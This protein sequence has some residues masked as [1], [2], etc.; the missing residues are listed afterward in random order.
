VDYSMVRFVG[1]L[2]LNLWDCG[3][4]AAF[5]Q[6]YF[7]SQKDHIFKNVEV[8]IH[9]FDIVSEEIEQDIESFQQCVE[10]IQKFSASA[11]VF[12]LIHKMD[13]VP[14]EQRDEKYEQHESKVRAICTACDIEPVC[15][16]TSIW[17]E[18]LY[19][20]WST[21]VT[22]LIPNVDMLTNQLEAFGEICEADEVVLFEKATFL[23]IAHATQKSAKVHKDVHRFEKISNIIK[24]FKLSCSKNS[25]RFSSLEVRTSKFTAFVE[26]FT[27]STYVM[28]IMSDPDIEPAATQINI[29][30]GRL[31]FD[32]VIQIID[33]PQAI[34]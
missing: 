8:L 31:H 15:F 5:F 13:L 21:I 2:V 22:A 33:M 17:D 12:V 26:S 10:A 9:V 24:Q 34:K 6:S 27:S 25:Q 30:S 32:K 23:V 1:N 28:V 19:R 16:R 11:K 3:G 29:C 20:A 14:E 7:D 18:T 4:Q